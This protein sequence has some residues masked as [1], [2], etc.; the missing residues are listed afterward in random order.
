M[1]GQGYKDAESGQGL[2]LRTTDEMMEEFSAIWAA[3][4][5]R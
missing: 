3:D 4:T 5:A 1:A 2:Y